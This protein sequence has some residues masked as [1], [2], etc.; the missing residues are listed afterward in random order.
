MTIQVRR[1]ENLKLTRMNL[2]ITGEGTTLQA[3]TS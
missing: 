3:L 2:Y 1:V